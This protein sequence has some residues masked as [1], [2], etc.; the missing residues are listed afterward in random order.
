MGIN[1][2][3]RGVDIVTLFAGDVAYNILIVRINTL[4]IGLNRDF[5][6]RR[7]CT[8]ASSLVKFD[9]IIIYSYTII[10]RQLNRLYYAQ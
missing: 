3:K 8:D 9:N 2:F 1:L 10:G 5:L 6:I 7:A 4:R